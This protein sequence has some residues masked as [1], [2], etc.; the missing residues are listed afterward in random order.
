MMRVCELCCIGLLVAGGCGRKIVEEPPR[1]VVQ[2][3][4][5]PCTELC[6]AQFTPCGAGAAPAFEDVSGCIEECSTVEGAF[7]RFWAY[8]TDTQRDACFDEFLEQIECTTDVWRRCI[9]EDPSHEHPCKAE[10]RAASHCAN[11][12]VRGGG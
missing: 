6:E 4:V 2:A 5:E 7:A 12:Y 1:T 9:S 11:P 3:R 10:I 8:Q